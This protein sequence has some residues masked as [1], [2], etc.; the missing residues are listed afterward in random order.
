M[1]VSKLKRAD[2]ETTAAGVNGHSVPTPDTEATLPT[3]EA[4]VERIRARADKYPYD[5]ESI[6]RAERRANEAAQALG[7]EVQY[8]VGYMGDWRG[9]AYD[10][11]DGFGVL[12]DRIMS[13]PV[14]L[15]YLDAI[16]IWEALR[17]GRKVMLNLLKDDKTLELEGWL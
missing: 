7:M 12:R 4:M 9:V 2:D 13:H 10:A 6:E 14:Y 3:A 5:K 15:R 17:T 16:S 8:I 1:A 11:A